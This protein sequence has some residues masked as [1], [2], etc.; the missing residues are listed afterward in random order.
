MTQASIAAVAPIHSGQRTVDVFPVAVLW[1][2]KRVINYDFVWHWMCFTRC[3]I[4]GTTQCLVRRP[5]RNFARQRFR[6]ELCLPCTNER[7]ITNTIQQ[8]KQIKTERRK[9]N[10]CSVQSLVAAMKGA[11]I[12]RIQ[13]YFFLENVIL[14][15]VFFLCVDDGWHAAQHIEHFAMKFCATLN[16]IRTPARP[17][18]T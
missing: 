14:S 8:S 16:D 3:E 9:V 17:F 7:K 4:I 2:W 6:P 12:A 18:H 10:S 5:G 13:F 11:F 1:P 15:V